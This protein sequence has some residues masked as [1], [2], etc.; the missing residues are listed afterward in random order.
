MV[1]ILEDKHEIKKR[2]QILSIFHRKAYAWSTLAVVLMAVLGLL[3]LTQKSPEQEAA[4]WVP[5]GDSATLQQF[6]Q[7]ALEGQGD[8]L[9]E[10]VTASF[11]T[12]IPLTEEDVAG[13][14]N[15]FWDQRELKHFTHL[16]K[17]MR[18]TNLGKDWL[19]SEDRLRSMVLNGGKEFIDVLLLD[20]AKP[21]PLDKLK[22]V[23]EAAAP[24]MSAWIDQRVEAVGRQRENQ[25]AFV[26]AAQK[27]EVEKMRE[28]LAAGVDI[29]GVASNHH[30]ALTSAAGADR[31]ES[32]R[33]LLEQ[34][35]QPDKAR[36]PGWGLHPALS[37][38]LGGSG[39]HAQGGGGQCSRQ[40]VQAGCQHF[41]LCRPLAWR[42]HGAVVYRKR[43]RS[44]H[45]RGQ[46]RNVVV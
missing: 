40:T 28:L 13:L 45:H 22:A 6:R 46:Q 19:P 37:G 31:K 30:T 33:F 25:D 5:A 1:G 39:G 15:E 10:I 7:A 12:A 3:F 32:V 38:P 23:Q 24:E 18:M 16:L 43:N 21:L 41:D 11:D 36:H 2:F 35:A 20:P 27:G 44:A 14:L 26:K 4:A 42:R 29:D 17:Y 8:R 34:G 9:L